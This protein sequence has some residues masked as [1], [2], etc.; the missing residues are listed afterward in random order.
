M[1][2][3]TT[4]GITKKRAAPKTSTMRWECIILGGEE[5]SKGRHQLPTERSKDKRSV[6]EKE[7][8]IKW[9]STTFSFLTKQRADI[10][11]FKAKAFSAANGYVPIEKRTDCPVGGEPMPA[12]VVRPTAC[13]TFFT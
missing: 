3:G 12:P 4:H 13:L 5:N 1:E 6:K 11:A 9:V 2:G 10:V 7:G 8:I